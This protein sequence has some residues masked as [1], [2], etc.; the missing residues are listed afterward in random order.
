MNDDQMD[1]LL[2]K[3]IRDYNQP[4]QL[5]REEMWTRI[6]AARSRQAAEAPRVA[7][8]STGRIWVWPSAAVAAA[9]LIAAGIGIGRWL[10]RSA[11]PGGTAAPVAHTAGL[12]SGPDS[13]AAVA[14]AAPS[15][16][17][18]ADSAASVI[19]QLR[20]ASKDNDFHAREFAA[21]A[22]AN[23]GH[24][25]AAPRTSNSNL[26]FRLVVLQHLAGTEAMITSFQA[27]AKRGVPDTLMVAWS[28]E[29]L[30]TTRMLAA[31]PAAND[32]VMKRL[33]QDLDFVITEIAQY[34][35][36]GVNNPDELNLIEQSINQRSVISKLRGTNP[37]RIP[38]AGT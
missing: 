12:P 25:P 16:G 21:A 3:G 5:P 22:T 27:S 19:G 17:P 23:G 38:S 4:G 26:A 24:A 13:S 28:R 6:Q 37:S 20:Q 11:L 14:S 10:E 32:P 18:T 36:H 15:S 8:R 9:L 35:A 33:L 2:S 31:S 34:S 29:L 1:E 30:G 7:R